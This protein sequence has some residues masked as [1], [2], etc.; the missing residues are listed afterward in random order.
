M[1]SLPGGEIKAEMFEAI[2]GVGF[3]HSYSN[4]PLH[5]HAAIDPE[6]FSGYVAAGV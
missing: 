1:I 6:Y 2:N 4:F 3:I 5:R